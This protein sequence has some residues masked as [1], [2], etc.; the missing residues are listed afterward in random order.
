MTE[1]ICSD[2]H[3]DH[4]NVTKFCP[5]TRPFQTKDE[6]NDYLIK[7]WNQTVEPQD[8][9]YYLGD[10]CFSGNKR[11]EYFL[12]Q[13]NGKIHMI[14]GNHDFHNKNVFEKYCETVTCYMTFKRNKTRVVLCH[15]PITYWH[16]MENGAIH[17]FGHTHG[18]FHPE[19]RCMDVGFDNTRKILN[20][21]D[22]FIP[23]ML[24]RPINQRRELKDGSTN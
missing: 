1:F 3:F 22:E 9:V 12:S 18:D 24:E 21:N 16:S 7:H 8:T 17:A 11:C 13:L 2:F 14:M 4:W 5:E 15:F 10:F 23:M 6:M 20:L 19:G